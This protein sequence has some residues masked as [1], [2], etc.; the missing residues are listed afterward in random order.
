MC[1]M[2]EN[3]SYEDL[4][5][6]VADLT[7]K[8]KKLENELMANEQRTDRLK[9]S[10][11]ANVSHELRTPMNAILGFSNLLI[12]KNLSVDKKE[13]YMEHINLSSNSL[14][15]LVD[16]MI[17]ASLLEAGEL[18]IRKSNC[19]LH[20]LMQQIYY[21]FNINKHKMDK[22]HIALL[23]K[24]ERKEEELIIYADSHRLSQVL[25]N[26]L[27]NALKFTKKGII[28]FGYIIHELQ[29]KVEFFVTDSGKG[30]LYDK[31]QSIFEK[32]EKQEDDYASNEGGI[33]LGLSLAKGLVNL[34]GGEIWLES[35]VFNGTTFH[36]T[37]DFKEEKKLSRQD[38]SKIHL[39]GILV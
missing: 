21:F 7:A 15:S 14:L 11:L 3:Q 28:E 36:F 5:D 6:Q 27:E 29:G 8:V 20:E 4:L 33:G 32:F 37:I 10:F 31:A 1:L 17:D 24:K 12:D 35:N 16:S 30:V 26:L 13:E 18:Q 38:Q 23:M 19:D 25:S 2:K 9:K 22:G 34:M 39:S